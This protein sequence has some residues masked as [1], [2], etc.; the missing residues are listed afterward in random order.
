VTSVNFNPSSEY[1]FISGAMDGSVKLWDLRNKESPLSNLK[2]KIK[3][4]DYKVFST[5]WN[6]AS[7][8]ISGG[9]DSHISVHTM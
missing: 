2:H 7:Q 4:D 8:I 6:G 9:S 3:D 5:A 1:V